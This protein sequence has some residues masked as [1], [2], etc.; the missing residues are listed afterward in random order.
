M[1]L[2]VVLS[3]V[4]FHSPGHYFIKLNLH[5][6]PIQDDNKSGQRTPV[7]PVCSRKPQFATSNFLFQLPQNHPFN[8]NSETIANLS[9]SYLELT[10]C[11]INQETNPP[12]ISV[13]GSTSLII[14]PHD[15]LQRHIL[16][17]QIVYFYDEQ[18]TE[19]GK[20]IITLSIC[21]SLGSVSERT[22]LDPVDSFLELNSKPMLVKA[23][24][25]SF[26]ASTS[27]QINS[28]QQK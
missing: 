25:N 12:S 15:A 27:F 5:H 4:S 13:V 26:A 9:K 21:K 10:A 23:S 14:F 8:S 6:D 16:D 28:E 17:M 24:E 19:I 3:E 7:S 20:C 11:L 22:R 18:K 2:Q 1:N